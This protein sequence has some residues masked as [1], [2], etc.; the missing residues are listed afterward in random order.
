M[1]ALQRA[2]EL[3]WAD[4]EPSVF[5]TLFERIVNPAKRSQLG[6]H[7]TSR[8]DIEEIVE[9]TLIWPLEREWQIIQEEVA[10]L[11][12]QSDKAAEPAISVQSE[13]NN[14][15][16]EFLNKLGS[17]TI[18]DPA[19]GSGNFLYVSL[20]MLKELEQKVVS[21]GAIWGYFDLEPKVHPRQLYGIEID[22][23]AHQLASIVVW[24]GYLQWEF[25]NGISFANEIPILNL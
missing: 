17:T 16:L 5:G 9:P 12:D 21:F 22:P 6:A 10:A 23:Y 8:S 19:C 13:A 14:K 25:Q 3:N 4:I 24:I 15:L 2:Y 1:G 7:Y 18:L 20:A 11:L